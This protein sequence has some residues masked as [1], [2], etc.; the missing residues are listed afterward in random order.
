MPKKS[1]EKTPAKAPKAADPFKLILVT[2]DGDRVVL[3]HYPTQEKADKL[4]AFNRK[5]FPDRT[6]EIEKA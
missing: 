4:L 1:P 5:R 2:E 6:F 3:R